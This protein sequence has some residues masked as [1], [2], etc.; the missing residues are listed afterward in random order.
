M[1]GLM[2]CPECKTENAYTGLLWVHC[3]NTDC[4]YYDA[5]YAEQVLR[6]RHAADREAFSQELRE[7]VEDF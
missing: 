3:I 4:R 1:L 6:D 5:R 7:M 2:K